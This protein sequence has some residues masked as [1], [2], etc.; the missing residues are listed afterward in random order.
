L[1]YRVTVR[2]HNSGRKWNVCPRVD[3]RDFA[4]RLVEEVKNE[5]YEG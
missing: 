4:L 1:P 3:I 2:K 5:A